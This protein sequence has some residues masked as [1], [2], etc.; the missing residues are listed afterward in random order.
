MNISNNLGMCDPQKETT[1]DTETNLCLSPPYLLDILPNNIY[2][3]ALLL[4]G[5]EETAASLEFWMD[6]P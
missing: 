2:L 3:L 5:D 4:K 1:W 6:S